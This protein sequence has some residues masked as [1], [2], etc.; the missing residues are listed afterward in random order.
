VEDCGIH[1]RNASGPGSDPAT[2][3]PQY[4]GLQALYETYHPRGLTI[5]GCPSGDFA[6]QELADAGE[7][8][9]F[10]DAIEDAIAAGAAEHR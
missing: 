5:L 9:A 6:E 8:G 7:I 2:H 10:E 3:T 1:A 4:A